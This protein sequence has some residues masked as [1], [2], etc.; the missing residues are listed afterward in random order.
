MPSI[1]KKSSKPTNNYI[2]QYKKLIL[3]NIYNKYYA[4]F[5]PYR[6]RHIQTN[7]LDELELLEGKIVV[8]QH[9]HHCIE[10]LSGKSDEEKMWLATNSANLISV[11]K[12]MHYKIHN[13]FDDLTYK[14]KRYLMD[15]IETVKKQYKEVF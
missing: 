5:R 9:V 2:P 13:H 4:A 1:N 6:E 3:N 11:S 15:K 8:A 14:Q 12:D 7:P 10:I